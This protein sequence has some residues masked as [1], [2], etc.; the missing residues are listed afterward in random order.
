MAATTSRLLPAHV[1]VEE[2]DD[3]DDDYDEHDEVENETEHDD[4]TCECSRL[5]LAGPGGNCLLLLDGS[6]WPTVQGIRCSLNP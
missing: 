2:D 5:R 6:S 3:D 4:G 1:R